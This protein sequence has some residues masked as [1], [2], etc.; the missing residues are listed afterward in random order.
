MRTILVKKYSRS[1]FYDSSTSRLVSLEDLGLYFIEGATVKVL[2]HVNKKDVT[3]ET[4]IAVL[5]LYSREF[6]RDIL[7]EVLVSQ[8]KTIK[9]EDT[10]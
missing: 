10:A 6:N 2:D 9:L 7:L 3:L 8:L 4:V 5:E 1:K